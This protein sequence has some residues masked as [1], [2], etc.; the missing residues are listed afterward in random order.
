ME[1]KRRLKPTA[2]VELIPMID[3]VFQLVVFFMVSSTFIL[4][5]GISLV[6]PKSETAQAVA[7]TKM[8]V[9]IVDENEVYLN[10]DRYA[11]NEI[12][13]VLSGIPKE[14]REGISSVIIE[15]DQSV[16]YKLMVRVL[17]ILRRN[18]FYGI[19]LRMQE[20]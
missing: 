14:E 16:S 3:V 10:K 13:A 1:F 2:T 19:N 7:M 12:D 9:T 18:G 5:P 11:L 4:T 17:D 15:G 8:V 20:E 6:L